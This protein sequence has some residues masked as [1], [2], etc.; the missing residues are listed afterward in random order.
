MKSKEFYDKLSSGLKEKFKSNNNKIIIDGIY[1]CHGWTSLVKPNQNTKIFLFNEDKYENYLDVI[2]NNNLLSKIH[3]GYF[4]YV[5]GHSFINVNGIFI[6]LALQSEGWK[7]KEIQ[8]V[9]LELSKFEELFNI[10]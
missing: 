9:D 1:D 3:D 6:D 7:F 10:A 4:E 5:F 2:S 8:Q